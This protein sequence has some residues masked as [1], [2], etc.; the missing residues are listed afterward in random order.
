[1]IT[2]TAEAPHVKSLTV[3]KR[4]SQDVQLLP[5]DDST[6][7]PKML[8]SRLILPRTSIFWRPSIWQD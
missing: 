3:Q 2:L 8:H 6:A 5:R 1:M 4:S 7:L